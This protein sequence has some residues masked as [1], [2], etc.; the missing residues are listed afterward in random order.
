MLTRQQEI[1]K[2]LVTFGRTEESYYL[3]LVELLKKIQFI[4]QIA[5]SS[6]FTCVLEKYVT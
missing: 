2:W 3:A 6:V 4:I 5:Q 1:T